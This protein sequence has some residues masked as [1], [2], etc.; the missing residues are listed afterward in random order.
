MTNP[1]TALDWATYEYRGYGFKL[2][3]SQ[4]PEFGKADVYL[5]GVLLTTVDCY[6]VADLGP[7]I[8]LT[9]QSISLDIHR[10]K[11]IC[12]GTKNIAASATNIT[13]WALQ[14]MR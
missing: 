10:V 3:M 5:D 8:V 7:Q 1:G 9:E 2:W 13:W 6:N 4:G 11:V 12:D 14:V